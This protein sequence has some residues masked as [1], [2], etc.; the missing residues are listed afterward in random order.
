MH[1]TPTR[2][3]SRVHHQHRNKHNIFDLYNKLER[4]KSSLAEISDTVTDKAHSLLTHSLDAAKNQTTHVKKNVNRFVTKK[5]YKA[6]GIAA[7][8]G[9]CLGLLIRNKW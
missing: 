2:S 6:A 5:P 1:K 9:L 7:I 3:K 4:A 8:T